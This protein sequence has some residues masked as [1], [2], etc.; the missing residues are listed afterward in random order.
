MST[1]IK[2]NSNLSTL[3]I[4]GDLSII[5]V[6]NVV[7]PAIDE[8]K[9]WN[10]VILDK[11][12]KV[13]ARSFQYGNITVSDTYTL[14]ESELCVRRYEGTVI[15]FYVHDGKPYVS[16]RSNIN[17]IGTNARIVTDNV[18][19]M[20][21]IDTAIKSWNS[22]LYKSYIDLC[23][24]GKVHVFILCGDIS[25]TNLNDIDN[26][27]S[28]IQLLYCLTHIKTELLHPIVNDLKDV[29][30][31]EY[32][33]NPND[34]LN[35]EGAVIIFN[36][37]TPDITHTVRSVAY[38]HKLKLADNNFNRLNRWCELMNE[39][40][41]LAKSYINNIQKS[42]R[43]GLV[44]DE[45]H[46]LHELMKLKFN[47]YLDNVV[48]YIVNHVDGIYIKGD[49]NSIYDIDYMFNNAI[50]S[51]TLAYKRKKISNPDLRKRLKL[52][53]K[54]HNLYDNVRK[55]NTHIRKL[56]YSK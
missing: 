50:G 7:D 24:E 55:L 20:T 26:K 9:F 54:T 27:Y 1:I 32:L 34:F 39:N 13:V 8:Y 14:N 4:Q 22:P 37:S 6:N 31:V 42:E 46:D 53:M 2:E 45:H 23:V 51:H 5:D 19:F 48:E 18:N 49:R 47:I 3:K 16:T 29:P 10:R 15:M 21:N 12:N 17:I 56:K 35:K 30:T 33:D 52:V 36:K 40:E 25:M 41:E 28:G 38:D 43:K 11:Y 44:K